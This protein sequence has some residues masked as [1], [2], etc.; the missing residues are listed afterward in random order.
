MTTVPE[1]QG[2]LNNI[3]QVIFVINKVIGNIN[4]CFAL[5][6]SGTPDTLAGYD[7]AGDKCDVTVGSGLDLTGCV[8]TTTNEDDIH[9]GVYFIPSGDTITVLENKQMINK[10]GLDIEGDIVIEGQLFMEA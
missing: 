6:F 1:E 4:A 9:S 2:P 7:A 3:Q 5:L 8:L 10:G